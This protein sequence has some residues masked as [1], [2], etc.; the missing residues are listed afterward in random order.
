MRYN[1]HYPTQLNSIATSSSE[2]Q[3]LLPC[4]TQFTTI[5]INNFIR[6]DSYTLVL[7]PFFALHVY[8][9]YIQSNSIIFLK[10]IFKKIQV[11]LNHFKV[12]YNVFKINS[13]KNNVK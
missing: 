11:F 2:V 9:E 13:L 10:A 4:T 7:S 8:I 6:H 5:S 3:Q 1:N 12:I